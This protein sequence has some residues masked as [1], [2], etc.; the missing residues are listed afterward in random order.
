MDGDTLHAQYTLQ[1]IVV[2]YLR[3]TTT[4]FFEYSKK[5]Y[6]VGKKLTTRTFTEKLQTFQPRKLL[7]RN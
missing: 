1:P 7:T 6:K 2:N 3:K 5:Q 4:G